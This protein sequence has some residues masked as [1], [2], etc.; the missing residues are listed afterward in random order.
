MFKTDYIFEFNVFLS[1]KW[2]IKQSNYIT[3]NE[4]TEK[5]DWIFI[6]FE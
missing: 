2:Y 6:F 4:I 3:E 1:I 5:K